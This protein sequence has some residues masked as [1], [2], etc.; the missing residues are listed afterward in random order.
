M[1]SPTL[2]DYVHKHVS[3]GSGTWVAGELRRLVGFSSDAR[4]VVSEPLTAL[5]GLWQEVPAG[6]A[7]VV[8]R[9][10]TRACAPPRML[11]TAHRPR[12]AYFFAQKT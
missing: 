7:I 12:I 8:E 6:S 10:T 4:A 2:A 11:R 3:T 9:L 1:H 5:P